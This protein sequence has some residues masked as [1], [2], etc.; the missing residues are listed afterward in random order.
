[1]I[2]PALL[3]IAGLV[4]IVYPGALWVVAHS[5]DRSYR[6]SVVAWTVLLTLVCGG[7]A[8]ATIKVYLATAGGRL[9]WISYLDYS[10]SL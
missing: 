1:M 5:R 2:L 10:C 8:V 4:F 6:R 7:G 3:L 9:H